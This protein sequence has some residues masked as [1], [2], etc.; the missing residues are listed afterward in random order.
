MSDS[1]WSRVALSPQ[2][3]HPRQRSSI[4]RSFFAYAGL[5]LLISWAFAAWYVREDRART[6]DFASE[7][8][9]A[10]ADTLLVQLKAM[11]VDGLGSAQSALADLSQKGSLAEQS[12]A[13][14]RE[15]LQDEITG[16]YI[17]A[18]FVGDAQRA[19]VA[20]TNFSDEIRGMPTWL[21][22]APTEGQ[23]VVGMPIS[24][25][26]QPRRSVLSVARGVR[27]ESG[28]LVYV[29]MWC[30][31]EELLLRYQAIGI[32]R[33]TAS[34]VTAD[35]WLLTGTAMHGRSSLPPTDLRGTEVI[36]RIATL[37]S[38]GVHV[39][40][41]ISAVDGKRKLFAVAKLDEIAPLNLVVSREYAAIVAPWKRNMLTVLWFSLGASAVLIMMTVLLYRFLRELNRRERQ[42]QKL[43]ESSL[44]GIFLLKDGR[45][46]ETNSQTRRTFRVPDHQTLYGRQFEDISA[47]TQADGRTSAEA[48]L[49]HYETLKRSGAAAFQWR[50]RRIAT[51]EPFE[52]EVHMSIIEVAD[53]TVT[54]VMVRDISE[55]ERAKRDLSEINL[56]LEAR[57]AQRTAQLQA[58]NAQLLASNRAL[59]DFTGAASHDLR[60]PLSVIAGQAGLLEMN[61]A[62]VLGDQG[63]H[64]IARIRQA[65]DRATDVIDGLLS[66]ASITQQTLQTECVNLSSIAQVIINELRENDTERSTEIYIEP[67]ML[68]YADRRLMTLLIGNLIGN[69]WKYSS[70][71][72]STWIRFDRAEDQDGNIVYCIADHGVGFD[73]EYAASLFQ[74]FRRLHSI[75]E[76]RGVGLGLATVQRIVNRYGG[77]VWAEAAPNVGAK[78]FFSLPN[79]QIAG[80]QANA[81]G[82]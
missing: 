71:H 48:I 4:R 82:L 15:Q 52:A 63:K 26:S 75:E 38:G 49:S 10:A 78:F 58:A 6:V 74:P 51:G 23:T 81:V 59:E 2:A 60:A 39:L 41:G 9:H 1:L 35:G 32:D 8:L 21:P 47:E 79:A 61:F 11:L 33:G 20:G 36:D 69:A 72:P 12:T 27:E 25:P 16:G 77:T 68:V 65:V 45:I 55:Q 40:D 67:D 19:V 5:L 76:F 18:L 34:I 14:V 70:K 62:G 57:V 7:Q 50:F 80:R 42:F 46:V 17:R 44:V 54:L 30:D 3:L 66:L 43:F 24:D 22:R 29:G 31:V 13:D 64:H 28:K 73:M 53:D 56:Q 37:P